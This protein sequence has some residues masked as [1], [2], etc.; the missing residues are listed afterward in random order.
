M[1]KLYNE[2]A[3]GLLFNKPLFYF[4]GQILTRS[5]KTATNG[6]KGC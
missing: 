3:K 2:W 5:F 4:E 6:L 1:K